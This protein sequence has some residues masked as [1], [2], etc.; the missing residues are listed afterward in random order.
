MLDLRD[1]GLRAGPAWPPGSHRAKPGAMPYRARVLGLV[2]G[3]SALGIPMQHWY[4]GI[5]KTVPAF[6]SCK[7]CL[8]TPY[9]RT[10]FTVSPP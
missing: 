7:P 2:A 9:L 10:T 6:G 5:R 1:G 3:A 4:C 8:A